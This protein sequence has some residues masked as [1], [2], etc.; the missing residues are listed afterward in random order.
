MQKFNKNILNT[1]LF[2][3]NYEQTHLGNEPKEAI[4]IQWI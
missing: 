1:A 4:K 2:S 3:Q